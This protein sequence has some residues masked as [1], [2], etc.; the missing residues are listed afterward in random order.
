MVVYAKYLV[1]TDWAV[2]YLRGRE[3]YVTRL[4]VYR[5]EGLSVSVVSLGELYEGV[6][7]A[8][9]QQ[10]KEKTLNDFL[11]GLVV[12][13]VTRDVARTFGRLRA[14]LRSKGITVADMDLLIG[15]TAV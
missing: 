14:E 12:V 2:Y 3:P 8:P 9:D 1:D 13:N 4:K 6:F 11:A 5:E 15:S 7:R 10:D